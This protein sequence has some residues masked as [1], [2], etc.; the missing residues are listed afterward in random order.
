MRCGICHTTLRATGISRKSG[1][2]SPTYAPCPRLSDPKAHPARHRAIVEAE[3]KAAQYLGNA[4]EDREAGRSDER[5]LE[6]A[7]RWLDKANNLRGWG[8]G[9]G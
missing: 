2:M 6:R 4:N 5:N 3:A 7:Q 9:T 1:R 8:E